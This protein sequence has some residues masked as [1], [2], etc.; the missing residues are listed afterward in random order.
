MRRRRGLAGRPDRRLLL[1]RRDRPRRRPQLP[2]RLHGD[3]GGVP[4]MSAPAGRLLRSGSARG[5]DGSRRSWTRR[6]SRKTV[7]P[8]VA[9]GD[10]EQ[11]TPALESRPRGRAA[12]ASSRGRRHSCRCR[13]RSGRRGGRG[14]SAGSGCGRRR[15]R[16]AE[17]ARVARPAVA[18]S[19]IGTGLAVGN[20]RDRVQGPV[21][22]SGRGEL[23][24]DRAR[25]S[26][27]ACPRSSP[28][29]RGAPRRAAAGDSS[30]RGETNLA[31]SS[32]TSSSVRWSPRCLGS[33]EPDDAAIGP[34][35][36]QPAEGGVD[37]GIGHV[38]QSVVLGPGEHALDRAIEVAA[39]R[40]LAEQLLE[41]LLTH[42][43]HANSPLSF[44]SPSWTLRRA[45]SSE[46]S[47]ARAMPA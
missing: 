28:R 5:V 13:R 38:D 20:P 4:R 1:R 7:L 29:A 36:Q 41:L 21:S 44:W 15:C 40:R 47:S 2:P 30:T 37:R 25:R 23:P 16:R 45:A 11:D 14:R 33:A 12:P 39:G 24:V 10:P 43:V 35:D 17:G 26:G 22:E 27:R 46:Q 32:R 18:I 19:P 31:R 6:A 8:S 42:R 9:T 34:C 3:D